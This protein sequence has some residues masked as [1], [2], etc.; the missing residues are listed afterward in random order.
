MEYLNILKPYDSEE[1]LQ[2]IEIEINSLNNNFC[3]HTIHY[4]D[5]DLHDY[6]KSPLFI[7]TPLVFVHDIQK[8]SYNNQ[9]FLNISIPSIKHIDYKNYNDVMIFILKLFE[10]KIEDYIKNNHMN[11]IHKK[12][13]DITKLFIDMNNKPLFYGCDQE[14]INIQLMSSLF[15]K[16]ISNSKIKCIIK[17][18]L[19]SKKENNIINFGIKYIIHQCLLSEQ[20]HVNEKFLKHEKIMA[21]K[22]KDKIC[23]ICHDN[24]STGN[25]NY[26]NSITN[27][28]CGHSFHFKCI[29][30]WYTIQSDSNNRFSCPYCRN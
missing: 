5:E 19:W 25:D 2:N 24:F 8:S 27:L 26:E 1:K 6:I 4:N 12:N 18:L 20:K 23:S 15:K 9:F 17:P 11:L 10:N 7:E 29:N 28:P 14:T 22:K 30:Q 13:T 3:W 21:F 16:K